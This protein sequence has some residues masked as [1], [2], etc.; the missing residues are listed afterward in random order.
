MGPRDF[1]RVKQR[2]WYETDFYN[3]NKRPPFLFHARR[4]MLVNSDSQNFT[5]LVPPNIEHT[6]LHTNK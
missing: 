5:T 6:N 3:D 2:P 4:C 1:R